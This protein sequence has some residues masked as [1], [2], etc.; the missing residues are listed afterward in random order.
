VIEYIGNLRSVLN[1]LRSQGAEPELVADPDRLDGYDRVILPGVGAFSL[2]M[3]TLERLEMLAALEGYRRTGKPIL[4]ICLGM[5][6]LCRSSTEDGLHAGLGW[7]DA[8]VER[9]PADAGIK[10][11]H[12]GWNTVNFAKPSRLTRGVPD[13]ADYYFVHSYFVGCTNPEDVLGFA[14]HGTRFAAMVEHE[15]VAGAQFHPEKSQGPGLALLGNFLD[16]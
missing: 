6:L 5:Q 7:I 13:G 4:G 11:P 15:N 3:R 2:A 8:T 16:L 12:I 1:A 14:E 9:F 10:V